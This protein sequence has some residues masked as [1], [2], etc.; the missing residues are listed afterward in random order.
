MPNVGAYQ[1]EIPVSVWAGTPSA[2]PYAL[3]MLCAGRVCCGRT[4]T[5][6]NS[7]WQVAKEEIV[8]RCKHA[9]DAKGAARACTTL[10]QH[11]LQCKVGTASADEMSEDEDHWFV[12][13][14]VWGP[15]QD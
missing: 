6:G 4:N 15:Y 11:P 3:Q 1:V 5:T 13:H 2:S 8:A 9:R 7:L 10:L 12:D 14:L